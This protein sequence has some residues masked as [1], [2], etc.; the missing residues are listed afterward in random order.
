MET[1]RTE[2]IKKL[3][4]AKINVNMYVYIAH[5]YYFNRLAFRMTTDSLFFLLYLCLSVK[6]NLN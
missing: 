6:K 5:H 2:D 4:S 1:E 3:N